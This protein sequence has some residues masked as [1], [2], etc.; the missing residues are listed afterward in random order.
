MKK[1][2]SFQKRKIEKKESKT[3]PRY[4]WITAGQTPNP[5][6]PCPAS[7][8]LNGI[9]WAAT[10]LGSC[11]PLV[12]VPTVRIDSL[13]GQLHFTPAVLLGK[14][15]ITSISSILGSSLQVGFTFSASCHGLLMP[16]HRESD[17]TQL[18]TAWLQCP[19]WDSFI[20]VS[21]MPAKQCLVGNAARSRC[22]IT[23][24][25]NSYRNLCVS[26]RPTLGKHF[27]MWPLGAKNACPLVLVL[28]SLM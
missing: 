18:H 22:S 28:A 6:L 27:P 15:S 8:A 16:P 23:P 10:P 11:S 12:L 4:N 21:S 25:D 20:L 5:V 1:T 17:L 2:F 3:Q 9:M 14:H 24:S 26:L 7:E 13:L 19:L